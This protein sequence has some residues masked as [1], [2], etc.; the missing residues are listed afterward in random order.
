[1]QLNKNTPWPKLTTAVP[2]TAPHT[3]EVFYAN[4]SYW[5]KN[6]PYPG[7]SAITKLG[8]SGCN[9][10]FQTYVGI[11]YTKSIYTWTNIVP[12][13]TTWPRGDRALH[14]VAYYATS[15]QPAGATL[16]TSIKDSGK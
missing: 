9:N 12:D 15:K 11:A 8:D 13:A 6:G 1:M 16:R 7:N 14:C 4:N 2:C 5:P 10:A 3:A